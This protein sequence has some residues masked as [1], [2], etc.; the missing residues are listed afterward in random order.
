VINIVRRT[1]RA[2]WA[3]LRHAHQATSSCPLAA[4]FPT[5]D[6]PDSDITVLIALTVGGLINP[7]DALVIV[8]VEDQRRRDH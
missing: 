4:P 3:G 1:A 7:I 5:T 8:L 2:T 6:R